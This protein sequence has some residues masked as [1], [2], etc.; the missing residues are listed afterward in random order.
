MDK[1]EKVATYFEENHPFKENIGILREQA[2]KSN[3]EETFKWM[4]PTYTLDGKNVFSICKFK[5]HCGIWFF[6]G[7][8]LKDEE[9]LLVN[10]QEGKT[11]AMRH[12]KFSLDE[13]IDIKKVAAYMNEAIENEQKGIK[14]IPRK[15]KAV[16][17]RIPPELKEA[18]KN[19]PMLK[20]TF[21]SLSKSKRKEYC[22]YISTAKQEKTKQSR[23]GKILPMIAEK[24]GLNDLYR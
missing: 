15:K 3:L 11:Q 13:A 22:E 23:L 21:N 6:N 5:K 8:F 17:V 9:K 14:L 12:W 16:Q 10:A 19:N 20:K 1:S 18:L 24:K 4:F 7:V 2:L